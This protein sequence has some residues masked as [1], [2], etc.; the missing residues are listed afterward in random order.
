MGNRKS[1]ALQKEE[2]AE[3]AKDTVVQEPI[4]VVKTKLVESGF[5]G[6]IIPLK[7]VVLG[8]ARVGKTSLTTKF[9]QGQFDELQSPSI[10]ASYLNK[11]LQIGDE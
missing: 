11:T 9:V 10:A 3:Q 7:V 1:S 2:K 8:D 6:E 4:A 5:R